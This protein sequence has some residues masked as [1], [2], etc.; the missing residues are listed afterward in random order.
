MHEGISPSLFC[1]STYNSI[2]YCL[3][4]WKF[5][6]A[7]LVALHRPVQQGFGLQNPLGPEAYI[8]LGV[9]P[10]HALS[11]QLRSIVLPWARSFWES[12]SI[13]ARIR[14]YSNVPSQHGSISESGKTP[15]I[16]HSSTSWHPE[17]WCNTRDFETQKIQVGSYVDMKQQKMF[18][19][20]WHL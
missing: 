17:W 11:H 8:S 3:W 12:R 15:R 7:S 10:P 20:Q 5:N 2:V 6:L 4:T 13:K 14:A 19:S 18:E 9:S 1:P 16:I